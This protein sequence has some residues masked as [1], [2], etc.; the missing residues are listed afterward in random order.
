[1]KKDAIIGAAVQWLDTPYHHQARL[2][3]IGV[4]CAQFVAAV[5]EDISGKTINTP[6]YSPEWHLHNKQEKLLDILISFGCKEKDYME[7]GDILTFKFGRV[8]SHLGI[9]ISATEFI[10]ARLDIGKVVINSFTGEWKER[11]QKVFEFP[12][13]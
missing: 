12:E 7:P 8:N 9:L 6:V 11:H 3:G 5:Y 13:H 10:H 1:M 2:K 4:D